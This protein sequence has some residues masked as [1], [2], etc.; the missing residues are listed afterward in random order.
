MEGAGW[1]KFGSG[2][3]SAGGRYPLN[4]SLVRRGHSRSG[5]GRRAWRDRFGNGC[6][7]H[8]GCSRCWRG[9]RIHRFVAAR[10][11]SKARG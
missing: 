5:S 6:T 2:P 11:E 7:S 4:F 9:S 1:G 8:R 3:A 10:T